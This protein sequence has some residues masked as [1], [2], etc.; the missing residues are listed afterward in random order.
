MESAFLHGVLEKEVY[1]QQ[2]PGFEVPGRENAVYKLHK[3]IS[4]LKQGS[5]AWNKKLNKILHDMGLKQSTYDQCIYFHLEQEHVIYVAVFVDDLIIFSNTS[6]RITK[7]Y[8]KLEAVLSIK[9]LDEAT[10]CFAINL[11]RNMHLGTIDI[12]Q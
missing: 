9:N 4:G 6:S 5:R 11:K 7:C 2:L 3:A 10:K 1:L 8:T 12:N